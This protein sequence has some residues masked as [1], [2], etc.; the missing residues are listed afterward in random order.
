M[1]PSRAA[2]LRK[3]LAECK[4]SKAYLTAAQREWAVAHNAYNDQAVAQPK[5]GKISGSE[6]ESLRLHCV[7]SY[8]MVL[9]ALRVHSENLAHVAALKGSL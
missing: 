5:K 3:A 2:A 6:T 7:S 8:E 9:D 1:S 4:E